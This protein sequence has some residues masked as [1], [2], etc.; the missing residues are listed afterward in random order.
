MNARVLAGA[1]WLALALLAPGAPAAPILEAPESPGDDLGQATI[2]GRLPEYLVI[3]SFVVAPGAGP[4]SAGPY[5]AVPSDLL[6]AGYLD[7]MPES[8]S[9]L[10][11]SVDLL[12]A[13]DAASLR[14]RMGLD[15]VSEQP[16]PP[17]RPGGPASWI[18]TL[19]LALALGVYTIQY[20]R[21]RRFARAARARRHIPIVGK[22][23]RSRRHRARAA[24]RALHASAN[25]AG[26]EH[27]STRSASHGDGGKQRRRSKRS[28]S[29]GS[30]RGGSRSG[31]SRRH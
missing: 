23:A 7:L 9:T 24:T 17:A 20:R 28:R 27:A 4:M 25:G 31:S 26:R 19:G 8:A 10:A 3:E 30:R 21:R 1:F 29:G 5:S 13:V 11:F 18:L 12:S 15:P 22:R 14:R 2:A 6:Q 16:V